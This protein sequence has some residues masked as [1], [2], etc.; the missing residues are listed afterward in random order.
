MPDPRQIEP[1]VPVAKEPQ[2]K[3]EQASRKPTG[4]DQKIEKGPHNPSTEDQKIEKGPHNPSAEDQKIETGSRKLIGDD[5][6][7]EQASRK[8]SVED[9]KS[10]NPVHKAAGQEASLAKARLTSL[11]HGRRQ[12]RRIVF[13]PYRPSSRPRGPSPVEQRPDGSP[14]PGSRVRSTWWQRFTGGNLARSELKCA[15]A[16]NPLDSNGRHHLKVPL[17][18]A[19]HS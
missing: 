15:R 12:P 14:A 8:L 13:G 11:E 9:Q 10:G 3:I 4:G 17:K 6:K 7:I 5:Q 18:S 16:L 19:G 1:R 2:E